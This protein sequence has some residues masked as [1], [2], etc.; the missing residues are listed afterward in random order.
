MRTRSDFLGRD[1]YTWWVGEVEDNVDPSQLGRVK[2]RVIG[3]YTGEG[4]QEAYTNVIKTEDLPWATVLLPTD[5]P[6]VKNAGTTSELQ[7]GSMVLGFFLDGDEGQMPCVLGAFRGFKN[8]SDPAAR[9][10]IADSQSANKQATKTPAQDDMAGNKRMDGNPFVKVQSSTPNTPGGELEETRGGIS[11]AEQVLPG[12]AVTN[13]IKPPVNAQSV[14]D[15]VGGP[16]GQGFETDLE[17]MLGELG[18]MAATTAS[19]PG[20]FVS[21]ATGNKLA[22]DKVKEH[23]GKICNFLAGGISGILAPLKELLAKIIAEVINAL[24]KIISKF[25]PLGVINAILSLVQEIF[26]IFCMDVPMWL[27]LV[28]AALSDTVNFANKMASFAVNKVA[29]VIDQA[30]GGAVKEVTGRILDGITKAMDRVKNVAGDVISAVQTAKKAAGAARKLGDAVTQIFEIDFTQLDWGSLMSIIK[31]ILGLLF[32]KDCGRKIKRPKVKRWYPLIG[33]TECDN[34]HDALVGSP[35]DKKIDDAYNKKSGLQG[36]SFIDNLFSEINPYLQ[37]TVQHLNG[38]KEINDAT[39]GKEKKIVSG[40]GGVSSFQDAYG[41]EHVNVPNNQTKIIAKD[42]CETIKGNY[43]LTVEGD[44]YL[45]VMGNFNEEVTGA[46]NEHSSNGPQAKSKGSSKRPDDST[47]GG[48]TKKEDTNVTSSVTSSDTFKRNTDKVATGLNEDIGSDD[49]VDNRYKNN[50]LS[51]LVHIKQTERDQY[52][53]ALPGG[54]F[55]PVDEIPFH[56]EADQWGRT[57][58]GLQLESKL[59]DD[60]EQKSAQRKEGDH[61]IAYTGEVKIQGSKVKITGIEGIQL[62]AQTVKTEANTIENVADGEIIN[63]ANWITSFLNAGRFEFVAVFNPFAALTGQFSM[64]KGAIV[65]IATDT[66][67][68]AV[69]PPTQTRICISTAVPGSMNDIITGTTSGVHNTFIAAP[70]GV[71][72]EF[73]TS[74]NIM[75]QVVTGMASYSVGTGYMA[76]GCGFGPHQVYGLP[77]L[78]N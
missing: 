56:P 57:P 60:K 24:V 41:N 67:F 12:N 64:V 32:Q 55:Y 72:T 29:K 50:D 9:T 25:I 68:P 36:G 31:M 20:G 2:V 44:F 10:V 43:V 4:E 69:A 18:E 63:E 47:S 51:R 76:T 15:G 54:H 59:E 78:L 46:K 58:W 26:A 49:A 65:D 35:Y 75:N 33:T 39:P 11:S 61:E 1:G 40:P 22:G 73:V 66:P 17:R 21:L 14:G 42:K 19:G 52:F 77:L 34:V 8:Q 37:E 48:A 28:Q 6:Q 45:K 30:I 70:S 23:L 7:P 16:G 71:I 74:G 3:W 62:N 38:A 53:K 13:P 5:K 27:G